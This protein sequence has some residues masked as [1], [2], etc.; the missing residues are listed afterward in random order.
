MIEIQEEYL[1]SHGNSVIFLRAGDV[2]V[3]LQSPG[4]FIRGPPLTSLPDFPSGL[5]PLLS[6]C[7]PCIGAKVEGEGSA[8]LQ[9]VKRR[10]NVCTDFHLGTKF[11]V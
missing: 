10:F 3:L 11:S 5:F 7:Y 9:G 1:E 4:L 2:K 8:A 6:C